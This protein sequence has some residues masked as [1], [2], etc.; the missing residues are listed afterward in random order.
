MPELISSPPF[1]IIATILAVLLIIGI[2]KRAVRLLIWIVIIFVILI[3]LG[4]A[5]QYDLLGWFEN[6][7]KLGRVDILM[8]LIPQ[9]L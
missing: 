9:T 4:I 7:I 8:L 5:K 2:A 3:C 1:L 6:L